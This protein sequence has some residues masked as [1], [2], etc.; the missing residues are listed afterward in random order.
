MV[1]LDDE[2]E[3]EL[4]V[5]GFTFMETAPRNYHAACRITRHVRSPEGDI[6]CVRIIFIKAR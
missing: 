3:H 6:L 5:I 4:P 1:A 2:H